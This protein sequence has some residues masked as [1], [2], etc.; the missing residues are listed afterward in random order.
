MLSQLREFVTSRMAH[1]EVRTEQPPQSLSDLQVARTM[2]EGRFDPAL[3]D[4]GDEDE[5]E[6]QNTEDEALSGNH[7]PV[8]VHVRAEE[9]DAKNPATWGKVARND[10]CPCGSGKKYK[11]C[12]GAIS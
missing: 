3:L 8:R 5:E 12:H 2:Q 6:E 7:I 10:S 11:H 9:R 4:D 1:L